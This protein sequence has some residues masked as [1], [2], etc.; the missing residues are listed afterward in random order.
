V[1]QATGKAMEVRISNAI[2]SVTA[3]RSPR[4]QFASLSKNK[5]NKNFKPAVNGLV[6]GRLE[7]A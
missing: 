4:M 7:L 5:K 2:N 1:L 6:Q 3:L